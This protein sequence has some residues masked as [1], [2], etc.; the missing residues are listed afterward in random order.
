MNFT[1]VLK[2]PPDG[3]WGSR[4]PDGTWSGMIGELLMEHADIG[5]NENFNNQSFGYLY[6]IVFSKYRCITVYSNNGK[7]SSCV[8]FSTNF[9]SRS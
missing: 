8:I 9:A 1:Y 4:K 7:E 6:K 2:K 5:I 3:Q